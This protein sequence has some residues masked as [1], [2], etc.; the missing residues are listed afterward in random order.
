MVD[1][2]ISDF[3]GYTFKF[4]A[5][6]K[7]LPVSLKKTILFSLSYIFSIAFLVKS[8]ILH[9]SKIMLKILQARIQLYMNCE[10][11][12][13]QA[14]KAEGPDIKLP[15]S[16]GSSKK[17]ESSRRNIYFYFTDYSK[18][19][20]CVDHNKL[21]KILQEMGIPDHLPPS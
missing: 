13:V 5:L 9:A 3:M 21:W 17:Q 8:F 20:D 14:E 16:A 7:M 18:A 4:S 11:L 1:S 19:F 2:I 10:L 12:D 15:T 6:R